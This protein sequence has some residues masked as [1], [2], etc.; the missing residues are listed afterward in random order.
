MLPGLILSFASLAALGWAQT[1]PISTD[2]LC[3]SNSPV[4]ATCTGSTFGNCCS[5]S[6][7]C[8]STSDYCSPL[9]CNSAFGTCTPTSVD[10]S[11][12]TNSASG[13]DNCEGSDDGPC[14][15][16]YG[17]CGSGND[18]CSTANCNN[19]FGLCNGVQVSQDGTC[20]SNSAVLATCEGS[21]FGD[22]CSSSGFCGSDSDYCLVTNC[23]SQ[24]GACW[25]PVSQDGTCGPAN[26]GTGCTGSAFGTCCS[27]DG[28]CGNRLDLF[29]TTG[30][31]PDYGY[32]CGPGHPC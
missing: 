16:I 3:G 23:D 19:A 31:Q 22:C 5:T 32:C 10:G 24:F 7:F 25:P 28:H 30:C 1:P 14:C 12:G 4:V 2:G 9:N 26:G 13:I 29:C 8:G 11:C 20:G 27:A 21:G 17:F 18:Y 15:S 6:G